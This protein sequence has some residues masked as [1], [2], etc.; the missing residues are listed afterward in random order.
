MVTPDPFGAAVEAFVGA[1][2][3]RLRPTEAGFAG[4]FTDD[5]VL[6]V[7]FDGAG[8][9][10]PVVGRAAIAALANSLR[11]VLDFEQVIV[12]RILDVDETIIVCEYEALLNRH[13]LGRQFR[14]RYVSIMSLRGGEIEHLREYG[15]PFMAP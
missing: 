2:D 4:L 5:A 14:R 10:P 9:G 8:D 15:G 12:H 1:L 6:D 13:D 11:G 3:G 7:P